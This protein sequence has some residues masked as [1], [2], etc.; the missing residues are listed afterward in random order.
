MKL[1]LDDDSAGALLA[2][3]LGQAGHDVQVPS[4]VGLSGDEDSVHF[5]HAIQDDRIVLSHN[6]RDFRNLHN[7][8]MIAQG[9][10][11]RNSDRSAGQ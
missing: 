4:D 6:H 9:S 7:L 10:P 5:A 2:R 8:I 11:S 3:L 1:Y